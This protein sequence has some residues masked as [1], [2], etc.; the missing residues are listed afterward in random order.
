MRFVMFWR[1]WW[2]CKG[3]REREMVWRFF[4]IYIILTK[5]LADQGLRRNGIDFGFGACYEYWLHRHF[6]VV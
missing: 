5:V 2:G 6:S 3:E 4:C 1:R